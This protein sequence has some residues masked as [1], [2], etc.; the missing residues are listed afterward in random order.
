M[1]RVEGLARRFDGADVLAGVDL[2][3]APGEAVGLIGRSGAGKSTIARC[4]VGLERPDAGAIRLDGAAIAPGEG[5]ARRRIQYLWQDPGQAL[6]PYLTAEG[7]VLETLEGFRLGPREARRSRALDLLAELGLDRQAVHRKPHA[8]SGGQ[9]QRVALAR[10]LAAEPCL[11]IL[12]EPFSAL[13]LAAQAAA[14]ATLRRVRAARPVAMLA[15]SHDLATLTGLVDRIALL[16]GGRIVEDSPTAQFLADPVHLLA[17]AFRA[18]LTPAFRPTST[19]ENQD[20]CRHA[21]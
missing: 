14:I 9:R 1:L 4:L 12:D 16:D 13:D 3:I 2:V 7:A 10:A 19:K 17:R 6:S 5:T 15:V 18:T 20:P 8:L 11:L 21:P